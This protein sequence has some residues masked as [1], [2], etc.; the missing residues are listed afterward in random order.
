MPP[1][2]ARHRQLEFHVTNTC[3]LSCRNCQHYTNYNLG[4]NV[5]FEDGKRDLEAWAARLYPE[6]VK[7]MGGEPFLNP[8]LWK[9]VRLVAEIWP[10]SSRIITTNALLAHRQP[11]ELPQAIRDTGTVIIVSD[12]S[13][14]PDY[15]EKL[16]EAISVIVDWGVEFTVDRV[17][18]NWY[19]NYHGQGENIAPF[20]DGNPR[21]S[22]EKCACPDCVQI[23]DGKLWKCPVV[24]YW[25]RYRKMFPGVDKEA[26]RM[27]DEYEPL[28][29]DATDV[30]VEAFVNRREEPVCSLCPANPEPFEKDI[31]PV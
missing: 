20:A 12:H 15:R 1:K 10:A 5:K 9:Y 21:E 18:P 28:T 16:A 17:N 14:R 19:A 27:F 22:W 24:A 29:L 7:L 30:Q 31:G 26:W 23:E 3:Q 11:K 2:K 6:R 25:P 8:E 13:K 4:G